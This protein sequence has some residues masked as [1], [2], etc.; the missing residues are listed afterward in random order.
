[1]AAA[2]LVYHDD[3]DDFHHTQR[4]EATRAAHQM[5]AVA[6]LSVD[7]LT[8]AAAFIKAEDDLSRHEFQVYGR[9]LIRQG[10]LAGAVFIPRVPAA[11]RERYEQMHRLPNGRGR[12]A[13]AARSRGRAIFRSPTSPPKKKTG[14]GRSATTSPRIRGGRPI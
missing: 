5:E 6:E 4:E 8:S 11:K 12:S 13:S 10:A 9:T 7:Q 3:R 14:G 1:M 2:A